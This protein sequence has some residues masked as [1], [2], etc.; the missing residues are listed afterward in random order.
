MKK[1]KFIIAALAL[2]ATI[3]GCASKK[4]TITQYDAN[5]KQTSV[6]VSKEKYDPLVSK[7]VFNTATFTGIRL[8]LAGNSSM[9]PASFDL[10]RGTDQTLTIPTGTNTVYAA[11]FAHAANDNLGWFNQAFESAIGTSGNLLPA[12]AYAQPQISTA[13]PLLVTVV[14]TNGLP[15]TSIPISLPTNSIIQ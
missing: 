9:A 4:V 11:P 6:S 13:N 10:G 12:A 8:H 15:V 14:G 7:V 1:I 2:A 5:G 3:T